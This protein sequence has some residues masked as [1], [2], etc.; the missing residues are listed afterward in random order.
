MGD[1]TAM[2]DPTNDEHFLSLIEAAGVP[3]ADRAKAE[4]A[5]TEWREKRQVL[6][7]P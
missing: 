2:T 1:F 3:D 5:A 4:A 7:M 6:A